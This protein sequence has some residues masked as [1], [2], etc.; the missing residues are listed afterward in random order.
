MLS[1]AALG[2]SLWCCS[3]TLGPIPRPV[4][5][6]GREGALAS[7]RRG[8]LCIV[9]RDALQ[10]AWL[11][12][13]PWLGCRLWGDGC[14]SNAL[15]GLLAFHCFHSVFSLSF[16]PLNAKASNTLS[17]ELCLEK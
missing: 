6:P 10:T 16:V 7:L 12:V 5:G 15:S 13:A 1:Q 11:P 14:T 3:G 17:T 8:T 4:S 9:P 2:G